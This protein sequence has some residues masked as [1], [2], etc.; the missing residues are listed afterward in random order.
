MA[1]TIG[2]TPSTAGSIG[3]GSSISSLIDTVGDTDWFQITLVKGT[4]YRFDLKGSATGE[5]TLSDPFLRLRDSNGT[6][7]LS[8]DDDGTGL[9]SLIVHYA[10]TSGVYFLSAGSANS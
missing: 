1:D 9:N 3:V 7:I 8:D 2:S 6:S 5:G 4:T 10:A